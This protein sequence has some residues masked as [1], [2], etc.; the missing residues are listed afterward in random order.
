MNR[1][2][3]R[4][5]VFALLSASALALTGCSGSEGPNPGTTS[6]EVTGPNSQA[7]STAAPDPVAEPEEAGTGLADHNARGPEDGAPRGAVPDE[8]APQGAPCEVTGYTLEGE[9]ER[10]EE[11]FTEQQVADAV[12]QGC[13]WAEFDDGHWEI[14]LDWIEVDIRPDGVV[15]EVDD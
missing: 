11:G 13:Q 5:T 1:R 15:K 3:F 7:E 9:Q 12:A 4:H 10:I 8:S 6:I 2:G 14:E